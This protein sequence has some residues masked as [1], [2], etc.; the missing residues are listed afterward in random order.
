M[1]ITVRDATVSDITDALE[2]LCMLGRPAPKD[3]TETAVFASILSR[4]IHD[5]DKRLFV[6]CKCSDDVGNTDG[7]E[8]IVGLASAMLLARCNRRGAE[9]YIPDLIVHS[10]YRNLRI[11]RMLIDACIETAKKHDCHRIRLESA[12]WREDSHSFYRHLG[13]EQ[14]ALSFDLS[15]FA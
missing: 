12:N 14:S 3:D 8:I 7:P 11:G 10:E 15:S 1:T 4:Y 5:G 2:L 9:L 6:A 13:F